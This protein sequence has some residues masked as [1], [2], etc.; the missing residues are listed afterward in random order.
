M[1]KYLDATGL[2][3]LWSKI[4]ETF[5]KKGEGGG[6]SSTSYEIM[7]LAEYNAMASHDADTFYIIIADPE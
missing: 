7:T 5:A 6:G 4:E 1:T 3:Y 2:S